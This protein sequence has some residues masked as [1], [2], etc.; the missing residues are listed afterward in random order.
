MNGPD[1]PSDSSSPGAVSVE[2]P[3]DA[4]TVVF[5]H[6]AGISKHMWRPQIE[7]LSEDFGVVTFVSMIKEAC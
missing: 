6:G 5:V 3:A 7:T 4:V 2:G 1:D